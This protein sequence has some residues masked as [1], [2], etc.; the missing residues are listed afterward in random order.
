M[1]RAR[2]SVFRAMRPPTGTPGQPAGY[3]IPSIGG[4]RGEQGETAGYRRRGTRAGPRPG[5]RGRR[6]EGRR[7]GVHPHPAPVPARRPAKRDLDGQGPDGH[8]P[9]AGPPAEERRDRDG[10][11]RVHQR[12]LADMVLRAG[13][14]RAGGTASQRVPGQE[15]ARA[16]QNGQ[17]GRA[18]AGP[19]DR[20]GL[21]ARVL[22]AAQGNPGPAGLHP[23]PRPADPRA[24]P[25]LAAAGESCWKARWSSCPA[26]PAS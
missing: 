8:G 16:A 13:G 21:A 10:D 7:G 6:G 11:A 17:T 9:R 5:C 4:D 1:P 15:P 25:V 18:V 24:H 14:V 22:R 3:P 19:A 26:W 20:D 23:R 2:R 12:L